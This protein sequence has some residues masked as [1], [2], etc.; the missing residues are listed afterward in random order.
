MEHSMKAQL[1]YINKK[2]QQEERAFDRLYRDAKFVTRANDRSKTLGNKVVRFL[3]ATIVEM[4]MRDREKTI[5]IDHEFISSITDCKTEQNRNL[6][7]QLTDIL[8]FEYRRSVNFRGQRKFYGYIVKFTQ[9]G[10][11]RVEEPRKRI[12]LNL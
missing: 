2:T 11:K 7:N 1:H 6:L 8:D 4:L 9:D 5:F 12:Y 3:L 10:Q